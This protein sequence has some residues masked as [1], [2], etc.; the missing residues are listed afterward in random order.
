MKQRALSEAELLR[1]QAVIDA[2]WERTLREKAELEKE[3]A[4]S[5]HRGAGDPDYAAPRE[6][7]RKRVAGEYN[8][9]SDEWMNRGR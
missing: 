3:G 9:F 7:S 4:R 5:C 8:P 1:R 6:R 2:V